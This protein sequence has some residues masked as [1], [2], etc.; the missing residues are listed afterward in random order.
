M[1]KNETKEAQEQELEAI[2]AIFA[3]FCRSPNSSTRSLFIGFHH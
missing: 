1:D 3:V 2:E